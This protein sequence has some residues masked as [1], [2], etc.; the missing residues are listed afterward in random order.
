VKMG[1]QSQPGVVGAIAHRPPANLCNPSG[2]KNG[3]VL[4]RT[5]SK[6]LGFIPGVAEWLRMFNIWAGIINFWQGYSGFGG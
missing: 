3:S 4:V 1:E 5:F 2:I 6:A